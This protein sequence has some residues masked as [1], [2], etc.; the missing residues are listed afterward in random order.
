MKVLLVNSAKTMRGGESQTLELGLRLRSHGVETAFAVRNGSELAA[1]LPADSE[2]LE[3]R[4]ETPPFTTPL[5][6]RTF[7]SRWGP[8]IVHAQTSKAHTH[9]LAACAGLVDRKSVV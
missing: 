8:D 1:A 6:L 7:I 9:A 3:A 2:S 4:F 5:H